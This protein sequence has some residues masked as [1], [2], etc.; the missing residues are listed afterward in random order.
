MA[1]KA[2]AARHRRSGYRQ[3]T[4]ML[5]QP[6]TVP[7]RRNECWSMDFVH[8][9]TMTGPLRTLSVLDLCTRQ[10]PVLA[11]ARSM[12]AERVVRILEEAAALYGRPERIV[13]DNGPEFT[14]WAM[15]RW[16][17]DH[18]ID[19]LNDVVQRI[20][21]NARALSEVI[22]TLRDL[23]KLE[24]G[25]PRF[26]E[27]PFVVLDL[28]GDLVGSFERQTYEKRLE[29]TVAVDPRIPPVLRGARGRLRQVLGNLL[30]NAIKFTERGR[31][32][33]RFEQVDATDDV[34][35]LRY[36]V[37]DTGRGFPAD[38][39]RRIFEPF[40]RAEESADSTTVGSGLGLSICQML[41]EATGSSMELESQIGKGSTF[42]FELI[43]ALG[44]EERLELSVPDSN[45]ERPFRFARHA[46]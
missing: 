2:L 1:L 37:V 24:L 23:P 22:D 6:M 8:D 25:G 32:C 4:R 16:A 40:V 9:R 15:Q 43:H 21:S 38:L 39:H 35:R 20:K 30:S 10:A 7:R 12:P 11:A 5:R 3:L 27:T 31:V 28:I 44:K 26:E 13:V 29:L 46:T 17:K 18:D 41:L 14:S 33:L 34:V 42:S 36:S 45:F 19:L